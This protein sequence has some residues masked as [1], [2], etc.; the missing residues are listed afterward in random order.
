MYWSVVYHQTEHVISQKQKLTELF[1]QTQDSSSVWS[2]HNH[3]FD[4]ATITLYYA[5]PVLALM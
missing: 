5:L 3:P 1:F 4:E 2:S